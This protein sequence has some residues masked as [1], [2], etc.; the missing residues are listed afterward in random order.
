M[1]AVISGQLFSCYLHLKDEFSFW[2]EL[3]QIP[4]WNQTT[5]DYEELWKFKICQVGFTPGILSANPN[6]P[7]SLSPAFLQNVS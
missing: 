5:E 6:Q 4:M 1:C 7:C 3:L 2:G